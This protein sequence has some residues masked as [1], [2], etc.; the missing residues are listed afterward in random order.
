MA[1]RLLSTRSDGVPAI[2][3]MTVIETIEAGYL[4]RKTRDG[5]AAAKAV[6]GQQMGVFDRLEADRRLT[7]QQK[8]E[9]DHHKGKALLRLGDRRAAITQFEAVL[10]GP[11]PLNESRLQLVKLLAGDVSRAADVEAMTRAL[12]EGFGQRGD[13][14]NS[15]FLAA[16]ESLPWRD[17]P[18]RDALI[19][20]HGS[21]MV[22]R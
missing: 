19:S 8:A 1:D 3:T 6:L 10:S 4:Y 16:V 13:V 12:L 9:L 7:V 22:T 18:W 11:H 2:D 17:A 20:A 14:T 5:K 21:P 15:V